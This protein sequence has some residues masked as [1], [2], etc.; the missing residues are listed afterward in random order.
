MRTVRGPQ[1]AATGTAILVSGVGVTAALNYGF[2]VV[3]TWLLPPAEYGR[4]GVL[5]TVL[6]LCTSALAAGFPWALARALAREESG[7]EAGGA[8]DT[9]AVIR[10][11]MVGNVALGLALAAVLVTVQLTTGAVLP[12][13]GPGATLVL[14]AIIVLLALG[15]VLAGGLQGARRFG[16]VGLS[17][18]G[19]I[20]VKVVVGLVLVA[21]VGLGFLGVL[22]ALF[23]SAAV[24]VLATGWWL[25]DRLPGPGSL[26]GGR[27]FRSA[28][29]MA[30]G[31]TAFGM[32]GTLDIVLLPAIGGAH[33]VTLTVIAV[34]QAA[35]VLARAPYLLGKAI[36]DSVFPFIAMAE[37]SREAHRWFV[38]GFRWLPLIIVPAQMVLLVSPESVLGLLFPA[39]YGDGAQL[40]RVITLGATGAIA[41]DMLRGALFARG[42]ART[43]AVL[44][45]AVVALEVIAMLVLVPRLGVLGAA[46]AYTG[47]NGVGA[48]LLAAAYLRQHDVGW[49]SLRTVVGWL[50]AVGGLVLVVWA[51]PLAGRMTDLAVMT[52]G[53]VGYLVVASRLELLP[54]AEVA[55]VRERLARV[56]FGR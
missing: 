38:A 17:R 16:A 26:R 5:L 27:V 14:A 45:P 12:G 11:A 28:L 49:L 2:G 51:A 43:V 19:E 22:W 29:P 41:I 50:G 46:I 15:Q 35:A 6:L 7:A 18:V 20:A 54:A 10:A 42:H 33:G 31:T 53:L 44:L 21:F 23:V 47:A 3:L 37:T 36:S 9:A 56:R 55:R 25:R 39:A 32:V 34:Y 48:L 52:L 4:V 8:G 1:T 24:V 30:V 13:M 40:V